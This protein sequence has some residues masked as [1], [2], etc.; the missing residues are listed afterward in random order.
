[1]AQLTLNNLDDELAAKLAALAAEHD[2]S[3]EDEA[4]EILRTA[5][6]GSEADTNGV[7]VQAGGEQGL[8][9]QISAMFQNDLLKD[10]HFEIKEHYWGPRE[11]M[12]FDA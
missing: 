12:S 6:G 7:A 9:T 8:G 5:V 3:V 10:F 4:R 1:M 2:R 11:P